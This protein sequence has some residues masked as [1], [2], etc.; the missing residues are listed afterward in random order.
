MEDLSYL[1]KVGSVYLLGVKV[2]KKGDIMV[3]VYVSGSKGFLKITIGGTF[4]CTRIPSYYSLGW[5]IIKFLE[6]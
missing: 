3:F 6:T 1:D 2:G 4:G 5:C